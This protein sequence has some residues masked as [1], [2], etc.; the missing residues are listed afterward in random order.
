MGF[1][2]DHIGYYGHRLEAMFGPE[3]AGRY[4]PIRA[5]M[6]SGAVVTIHGDHPASTI[7]A[8]RVMTLPVSR[9][10]PEGARLGEAVAAEDAFTMMT[11]NAARQLGLDEQIGS[12]EPG[13]RA[14]LVM[15]DRDPVQAL[16]TGEQL[17]ARR[18]WIAGR[19]VDQRAWSLDRL[20]RLLAAAWGQMT[21]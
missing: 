20:G 10:T 2:P 21:R 16:E 13:K 4:M 6:E 5:A 3:R 9:L 15:F 1:F 11:I 12:L 19:P 7:D 17:T 8:A 14:D 18:T